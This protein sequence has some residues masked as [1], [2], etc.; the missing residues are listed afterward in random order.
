[1]TCGRYKEYKNCFLKIGRYY[2]SDR[3]SIDIQNLEDGPIARLTVNIPEEKEVGLNEAFVDTNNCPW[4]L[5][6][7]KE[8]NLG[9]VTDRL[10]SSGFCLYPLVSFNVDE[11]KK[12]QR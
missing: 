8:Y 3:L 11:L 6:F 1:M 7:V 4:A 2:V 9:T 12:W 10:G 5:D